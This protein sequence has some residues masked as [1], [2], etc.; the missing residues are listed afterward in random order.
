[1]PPQTALGLRNSDIS[2]QFVRVALQNE[3]EDQ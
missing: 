3:D 1:M 2:N